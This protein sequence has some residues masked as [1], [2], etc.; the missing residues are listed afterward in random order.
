M[1]WLG[2]QGRRL[3]HN[4]HMS[5]LSFF[6]V[7]ADKLLKMLL[8]A[9]FEAFIILRILRLS[10]VSYFAGLMP[11][12]D[13]LSIILGYLLAGLGFLWMILHLPFVCRTV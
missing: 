6:A 5:L 10:V 9:V 8:F 7:S 11:E 4:C 1:Y 3:F 13:Y 12:L 2:T